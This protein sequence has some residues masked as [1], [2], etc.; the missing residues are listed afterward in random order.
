METRCELCGTVWPERSLQ[1]EPYGISVLFGLVCVDSCCGKLL[2]D[3]YKDLGEV[4]A[5]RWNA[6]HVGETT[7]KVDSK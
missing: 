1:E 7:L 6:E 5:E 2:D 3:L 4:F